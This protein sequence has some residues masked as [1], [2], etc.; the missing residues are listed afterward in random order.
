MG[1]YLH[2]QVYSK[3]GQGADTVRECHRLP[4]VA[5]PVGRVERQ[6]GLDRPGPS[7]C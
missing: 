2:H 4:G 1:A 6:A 5:S 7:G 3:F